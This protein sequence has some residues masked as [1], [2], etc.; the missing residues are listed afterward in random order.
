M[1][2]LVEFTTEIG[3]YRGR[4]VGREAAAYDLPERVLVA[5]ETAWWAAEWRRPRMEWCRWVPVSETTPV[6]SLE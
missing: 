2:E 6:D 1:D 5:P 4:V 3:T